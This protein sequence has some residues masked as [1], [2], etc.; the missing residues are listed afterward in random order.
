MAKSNS[1]GMLPNGRRAFKSEG[2]IKALHAIFDHPDYSTM[3]P[4]SKALL[5]DLSRQ[6]NGN[7]NGDLTLAPKTM[8]KW[9]WSKSTLLRHTKPL[10]ENNWI[11]KAGGKRA[12]NGYINL[13]GLTWLEVNEC[14][15]K[16]FDESY[17]HKPR[18]LK[19]EG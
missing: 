11:F 13:F 5:W 19:I 16:L 2:Y 10:L 15:G 18:S 12:R 8:I 1:K 14:K 17:T 7:N 4:T 3:D 6:Y 9:G